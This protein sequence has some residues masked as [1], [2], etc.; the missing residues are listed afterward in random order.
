MQ[1]NHEKFSGAGIVILLFAFINAIVLQEGLT[2]PN[3]YQFLYITI[4]LPLI[5][6]LVLRRK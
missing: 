5:F 2:Q 4:P 6:M 1:R 3:W